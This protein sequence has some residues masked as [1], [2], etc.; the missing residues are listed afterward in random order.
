VFDKVSQVGPACHRVM[1]LHS[2]WHRVESLSRSCDRQSSGGKRRWHLSRG[3]AQTAIALPPLTGLLGAAPVPLPLVAL[4]ASAPRVLRLPSPSR[5]EFDAHSFEPLCSDNDA[6]GARVRSDVLK[7]AGLVAEDLET[8]SADAAFVKFALRSGAA[9]CED[10][11]AW[12]TFLATLNPYLL[13]AATLVVALVELL[14]ELPREAARMLLTWQLGDD[15]ALRGA[16][17]IAS[18]AGGWTFELSA[19][20]VICLVSA[21]TRRALVHQ[22]YGMPRWGRLTPADQP[23]PEPLE[24][25]VDSALRQWACGEAFHLFAK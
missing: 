24:S 10:E 9:Y 16:R 22:L 3:P 7:Q 4:R 20:P 14:W 5:L 12:S 1:M 18:P 21:A 11:Q 19:D 8:A 13:D 17:K 2:S 25:T 6:L 15:L 23:G